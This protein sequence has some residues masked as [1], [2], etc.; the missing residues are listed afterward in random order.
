MQ[1]M[2]RIKNTANTGHYH[3]HE[4]CLS[5]FHRV[6]I[7]LYSQL[8]HPAADLSVKWP[9]ISFGNI[10]ILVRWL[11]ARNNVDNNIYPSLSL[12]QGAPLI[13]YEFLKFQNVFWFCMNSENLSNRR[14][15]YSVFAFSVLINFILFSWLIRLQFVWLAFSSVTL[16][17]RKLQWC[18]FH[19]LKGKM[20][21]IVKRKIL[22]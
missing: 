13:S 21:K 5:E 22:I 14:L 20:L 9:F 19:V 7:S 6:T 18:G 15:I 17:G 16:V 4:W 12:I 10:C 11:I 3:Y 2:H 1:N 8:R